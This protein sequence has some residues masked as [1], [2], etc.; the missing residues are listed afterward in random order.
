MF[1]KRVVKLPVLGKKIEP[2]DFNKKN[3]EKLRW[4]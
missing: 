1:L 4:I 3:L 2:I